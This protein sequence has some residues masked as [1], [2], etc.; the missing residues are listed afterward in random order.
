MTVNFDDPIKKIIKIFEKMHP[1]K[2]VDIIFVYYME[3]GCYA[4]TT[5]SESLERTL[6]QISATNEI[7]WEGMVE[8]FAHELAHVGAG[9]SAGH[10][11]KWIKEFEELNQKR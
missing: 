5:F 3:K 10:G 8:I 6:I 4:S 2:D 7:T 1:N 9:A 11:E